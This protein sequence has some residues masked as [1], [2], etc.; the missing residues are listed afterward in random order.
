MNYFII[1]NDIRE[2]SKGKADISARLANTTRENQELKHGLKEIRRSELTARENIEALQKRLKEEKE[3]HH[4][5]IEAINGE[6]NHYKAQES[7]KVH[8]N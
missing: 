1:Q 7:S 3:I 6:L 8:C 2:H 4:K 5:R